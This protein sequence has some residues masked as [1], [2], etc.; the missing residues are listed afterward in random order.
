M[1]GEQVSSYLYIDKIYHIFS[2]RNILQLLQ[3][4]TMFAIVLL[5]V[6]QNDILDLTQIYI[7]RF[8]TDSTINQF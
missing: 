3:N 5:Q 2:L 7:Y 8:A 1:V 6:K 4:K